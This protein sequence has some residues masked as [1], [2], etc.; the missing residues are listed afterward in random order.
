MNSKTKQ[1]GL[2]GLAVGLAAGAV[3]VWLRSKRP[4]KKPAELPGQSRIER[5]LDRT[6]IRARR[7]AT[8]PLDPHHRYVIFSDHHKG[9]G[10]EADDFAKCA[11]TYL[12]ALVEYN[13]QGF[14]LIILG[15]SEELWENQIA[16]VMQTYPEV[17]AAEGRFY[18]NRYIRLVGN[19]DN[20][21][22]IETNIRRYLDPYFP[23]INFYHGLVFRYQNGSEVSGE[24]L[25]AHGQQ[26]TLDADVFDFL[27]PRIL[28]LY[29]LFQNLTG[30]GHT[31][32]SRD[33]C[34]RGQHDTM[35]YRWASKQSKLLLIAGHTHRPVWSSRTH[36]EKLLGQFN[37]LLALEPAQRSGDF[38]LQAEQLKAEI[39]KRAEK[40]PPCNDTIKTRPC[41]FNTGCCRFDDG[42]ITGIELEDG[43]LRLVKWGRQMGEIQRSELEKAPLSKIFANL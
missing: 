8:I 10:D 20:A 13:Q 36:L 40:E 43:E 7:Q 35:M 22:E 12:K 9:A 15:D 1:L 21:W 38:E 27:P 4:A 14:T 25:L 42:D 17:F 34:L 31:S 5:A 23:G 39:E 2:A 19:H 28:P 16:E 41:Y 26:G 6:L 3:F 37:E 33:D 18:P 32:P 24:I 30:L 29:R 11:D